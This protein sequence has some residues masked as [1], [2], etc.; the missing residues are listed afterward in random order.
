MADEGTTGGTKI[1]RLKKGDKD[2]TAR[3]AD[4]MNEIIDKLN[5]LHN[6]TV[7]PQGAGKFIYADGNIVLQLNTTDQCPP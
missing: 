7:S 1:E 3:H 4:V 5:A 6:M 2:R